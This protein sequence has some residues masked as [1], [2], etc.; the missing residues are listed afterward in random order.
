M[1]KWTIG[2]RVI[3]NSGFLCVV[4]AALVITAIIAVKKINALSTYITDNNIPSLSAAANINGLQAE[5]MIRNCKLLYAT[6][7]EKKL[8]NSEI[9]K[10]TQEALDWIK[11]YEAAILSDVNRKNFEAFQQKKDAYLKTRAQFMSALD[12]NNKDEAKRLLDGP[13]N[14]T[15]KAYSAAGDVLLDHNVDNGKK[16]GAELSDVVDNTI[17]LLTISGTICVLIGIAASLIAT[18]SVNTALKS[19]SDILNSNADQVA[20][21]SSQVSASSQSLAEGASEQAASLEET[22]S[23]MEEMSSIVQA[24]ATSAQS[25]KS[26][27][28][29]TRQTTTQNVEH[30]QQLKSS[31]GEAQESSKQLT[32]AMEAIKTSSDSISKII[33]TIDEIAF[34]TNILALNAAVEA[35][36][37]GEA[38]MGFAVVADEVRNLA[39][40]SADAAKETATIIEDS[41]H[42]GET[43]VRINEEVVHKLQDIEEKSHQ[44]DTGLKEILEKV[45]KVDEAMGQIATASK[46]QTQGIGQVNTAITQMDKVTQT[47]AANAEETASAAEELNAQAEELKNTVWDLLA[48]VEGEKEGGRVQKSH[49]PT[50]VK[51]L[52]LKSTRKPLSTT[53]TKTSTTPVASNRQEPPAS[54]AGAQRETAAKK[55]DEIPMDSEFKDIP[56]N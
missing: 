21:A 52:N 26:L 18:R 48:L 37:A 41:I 3:F 16:K 10:N 34:Q 42:K 55:R 35:A 13:L 6:P 40:R 8:L 4:I 1:K 23:S 2:K 17:L 20:S 33:K 50:S 12:S 31:V 15:Y 29:E 56:M 38:G 32:G 46:E 11:K 30:V 22:S 44:V 45:G 47:N 9:E 27:A 53:P 25:S 28:A 7:E 14:E 54:L 36:R 19:I 49:T 39:K 51:H 24:N 43:G 5:N